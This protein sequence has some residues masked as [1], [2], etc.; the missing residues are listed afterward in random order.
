MDGEWFCIWFR[1]ITRDL[2][3]QGEHCG[4]NRVYRIMKEAGLDSQRG[5]KKHPEFKGGG[6]SH[7]AQNTLNRQLENEQACIAE[8]MVM[9]A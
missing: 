8:P 3:D 1:N 4:K 5:Y 2:K 7:V 6:V 9:S